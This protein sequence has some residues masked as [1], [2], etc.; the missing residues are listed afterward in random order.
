M[1]FRQIDQR[2]PS[3]GTSRSTIYDQLT[4]LEQQGLI[5]SVPEVGDIP[6]RSRGRTRFRLSDRGVEVLHTFLAGLDLAEAP[7]EYFVLAVLCATWDG[8]DVTLRLLDDLEHRVIARLDEISPAPR[9][10]RLT[11][12]GGWGLVKDEQHALNAR[13]SWIETMRQATEELTG[14]AGARR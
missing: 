12:L 5:E 11:E 6:P 1:V 8:P 4:R 3:W 2:F 14:G 13:L 9:P 10:R 7:R